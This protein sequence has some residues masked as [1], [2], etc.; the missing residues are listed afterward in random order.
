MTERNYFSYVPD[1][2]IDYHAT[3]DEAIMDANGSDEL[4]DYRLVSVPLPE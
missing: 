4:C 1:D 2:G 3:T